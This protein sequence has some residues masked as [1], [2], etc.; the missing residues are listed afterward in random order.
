ML[1]ERRR[2]ID[3]MSVKFNRW[4]WTHS[5]LVHFC[6]PARLSSESEGRPLGGRQKLL[7]QQRGDVILVGWVK[8]L[9][10]PPV[11]RRGG[12]R[13]AFT[14]PTRG[15]GNRLVGGYISTRRSP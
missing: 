7:Y 6:V 14:H 12:L 11:L 9:R 10:N 5:S 8:A 2:F 13:K 3:G 1:F 4:S 15:F